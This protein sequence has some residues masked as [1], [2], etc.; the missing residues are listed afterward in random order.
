MSN[1][2]CIGCA[3][4]VVLTSV[5]DSS[6]GFIN[7]C[8]TGK[9]DDGTP[10]REYEASHGTVADLWH[11]HLRGEETSLNPLGLVEALLGAIEHSCKIYSDDYAD[12]AEVLNFTKVMRTQVH[13]AFVTGAGTRDLCGPDGLTTEAFIENIAKNIVLA[14]NGEDPQPAPQKRVQPAAPVV[15]RVWLTRSIGLVSHTMVGGNRILTTRP[16]KPCLKTS[17]STAMVL[18]VRDARLRLECVH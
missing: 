13:R 14:L 3:L 4:C 8:L 12:S 6:P 7:S 9:A 17:I 11:A 15:R 18:L 1:R 10:I 5:C 16:S 2:C